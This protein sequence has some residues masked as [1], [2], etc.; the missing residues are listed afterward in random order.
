MSSAEWAQQHAVQPSQERFQT[1]NSDVVCVHL[2]DNMAY[3]KVGS[4]IA[5]Q[6][7]VTLTREG[8]FAHGVGS[9]LKKKFTGEGATLVK[10]VAEGDSYIYFADNSKK[11]S[12]IHLQ[13]ENDTV[14]VNGNDVLVFE[15]SVKWDIVTN[16]SLG[17]HMQGGWFSMKFR[18]PGYIAMTTHGSPLPLTITPGVPLCTDPHNTVAWSGHLSPSMKADISFK[19]LIGRGSGDT[20]QMKFDGQSGFVIIQTTEEKPQPQ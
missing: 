10:A 1:P 2:Q 3:A 19:S 13:D 4:M 5:Y 6:G 15:E 18:G 14:V 9:Y 11:V 17:G 12:V 7:K 16:S 8:M 20:F